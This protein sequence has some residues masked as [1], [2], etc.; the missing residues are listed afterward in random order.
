MPS[1]E[2]VNLDEVVG[3]WK[4]SDSWVIVETHGS[5]WAEGAYKNG[6]LACPI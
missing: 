6:R 3:E 2:D 1:N 4:V 5:N